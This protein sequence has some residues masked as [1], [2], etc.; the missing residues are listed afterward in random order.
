MGMFH[1][2]LQPAMKKVVFRTALFAL[3][4]MSLSACTVVP[5]Q[6]YYTGPRVEIVRPQPAPYYVTPYY[7]PYYAPRY[8]YR[9]YRHW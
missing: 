1:P 4:A 5:P 8:E 2:D 9:H 3:A 6:V 7:A